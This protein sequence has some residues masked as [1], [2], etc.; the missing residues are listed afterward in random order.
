MSAKLTALD[1]VRAAHARNPQWAA[2]WLAFAPWLLDAETEFQKGHDGDY[3]FARSEKV[4]GDA[5]GLTK[6]GIDQRSHPSVNIER[7]TPV[8][9]LEI[10]RIEYWAPSLADELPFGYGEFD[11]DVKVNGGDGRV[12]MQRGLNALGAGLKV[13]GNIGRLS[14]GAMQRYGLP[15]V[16]AAMDQRRARY[17]RLSKTRNRGKFLKGWLNRCDS[18]EAWMRKEVAA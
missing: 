1:C 6:F 16:W 18:L 8:D 9:A 13:D 11:C 5:G 4:A 12:M 15:G 7:L 10:Y 14:L 17:V 2:R 3:L